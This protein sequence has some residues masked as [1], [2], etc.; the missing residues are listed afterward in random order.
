[1]A[2][3]PITRSNNFGIKTREGIISFIG[4]LS[5]VKAEMKKIKA[6]Q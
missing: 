5:E 6:G 3:V 1:M 2:I 4:S